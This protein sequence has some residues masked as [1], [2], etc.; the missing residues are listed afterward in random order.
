MIG[1][2]GLVLTLMGSLAIAGPTR[3]KD[4]NAMKAAQDLLN[5]ANRAEQDHD[6]QDAAQT[7]KDIEIKLGKDLAAARTKAE[8]EQI[9]RDRKAEKESADR[10]RR[11]RSNEEFAEREERYRRRME[12]VEREWRRGGGG[13]GGSKGDSCF[14]SP[15]IGKWVC[16]VPK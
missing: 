11:R 14:Y 4:P 10:E 13:S 12:E 9:E 7:V 3:P 2:L 6:Y 8:R 1:G 15:Q 16:P 5:R